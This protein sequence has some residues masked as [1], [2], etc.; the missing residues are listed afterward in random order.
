MNKVLNKLEKMYS[1][2]AFAEGGEHETARSII[3]EVDAAKRKDAGPSKR[4]S[5]AGIQL[6]AA[7]K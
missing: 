3:R 6:A 4:K 5:A 1:A 2:V 7:G